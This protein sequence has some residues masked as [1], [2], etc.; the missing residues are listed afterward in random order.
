[1]TDY[2]CRGHKFP[3]SGC[4][5]ERNFHSFLIKMRNDALIFN[6]NNLV[7][8]SKMMNKET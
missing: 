7:R 2:K 3:P 5:G 1:M 8:S 4:V 6:E